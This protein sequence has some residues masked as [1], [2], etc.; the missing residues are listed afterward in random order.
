[1]ATTRE[2]R[3]GWRSFR[4]TFRWKSKRRAS[5]TDS[6]ART[7]AAGVFLMIG[8]ASAVVQVRAQ[9]SCP[10]LTGSYQPRSTALIDKFWVASVPRPKAQSPQF[11]TFQ[12][13]GGGYTL[14]WHMQRPDVLAA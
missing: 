5:S 9:D 12:K 11:A 7:H 1:E 14:I 4:S 13:N 2:A 8:R 10:D 3:S 6:H